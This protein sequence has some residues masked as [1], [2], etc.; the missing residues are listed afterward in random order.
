VIPEELKRTIS[1]KL[2]AEHEKCAV[3]TIWMIPTDVLEA[4]K[5]FSDVMKQTAQAKSS[6]KVDNTH[7]DDR[8]TA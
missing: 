2:E 7:G 3:T 5:G 6:G 4:V 8:F 1:K